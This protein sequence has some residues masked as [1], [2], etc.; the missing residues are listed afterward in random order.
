M[1]KIKVIVVDDHK[2]VRES[3]SI[4][5]ESAAD[6]KVT[7]SFCSGEELITCLKDVDADVIVMDIMLRGMSGIEATRWVKERNTKIR[8]ILLSMGVN[9][10]FLSA[11]I[12]SGIDG[13]LTKE[14]D[15]GTVLQA[16]RQVCRGE[17]YFNEAITGLVFN[18]FI[19][20]ETGI[21]LAQN[22]QSITDLTKREIEIFNL[23]VSG[24]S[25][26][27][28]AA[29]LCISAKTVD[30]HKSHIFDKLGVR[31]AAELVKYAIK[32]GLMTE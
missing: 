30:T 3:L 2:L 8:V 29:D 32:N 10:E 21:R 20:K 17:R 16:I 7:G 11:G 15:I 23:V 26:K 9:K 14:V 1:E 28:I 27:E 13:Y 31:N 22:G 24:K 19:K 4:M 18:D 5:L 6:I 25:N 12:Q